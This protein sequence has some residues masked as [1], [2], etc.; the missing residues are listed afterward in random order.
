MRLRKNLNYEEVNRLAVKVAILGLMFGFLLHCP[1]HRGLW[2][3]VMCCAL[4]VPLIW[5]CVGRR[6]VDIGRE[7]VLGKTESEK[8][9]VHYE[10]DILLGLY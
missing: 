4:R 10:S 8:T 3:D 9:Y 1:N 6:R 2:H 7:S 5:A